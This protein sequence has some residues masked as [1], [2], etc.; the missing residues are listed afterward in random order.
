MPFGA[1]LFEK[2]FMN[3]KKA[4]LNFCFLIFICNYK[5]KHNTQKKKKNNE[6]LTVFLNKKKLIYFFCYCCYDDS[7]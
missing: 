5:T 1:E 2:L 3:K 6:K 4:K 7:I